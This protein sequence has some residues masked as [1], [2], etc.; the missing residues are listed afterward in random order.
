MLEKGSGKYLAPLEPR[1]GEDVPAWQALRLRSSS[2]EASVSLPVPPLGLV[3]DPAPC[4]D[5][6]ESNLDPASKAPPFIKKN[7]LE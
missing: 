5:T 3:P 7:L 2:D 4:L 1:A 6:L